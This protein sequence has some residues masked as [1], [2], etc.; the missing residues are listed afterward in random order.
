MLADQYHD[1][2]VVERTFELAWARSH[3]ELRHLHVPP[4]AAQLYQR[5]ASEVIFPTA[6]H[7]APAATIARNRLGQSGLWRHGVS[8]DDPIVL[9]RLSRPLHRSLLREVLLAHEFW[10][11]HG[12]KADLVV[13]NDNAAGYFDAMHEQLREVV[14]TTVRMPIDKS[15][16][17]HLLR[18]AHLQE[19]DDLLLNAAAAV[20]LEGDRGSLSQQFRNLSM[21]QRRGVRCRAKAARTHADFTTT[22]VATDADAG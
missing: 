21:P 9:V 14:Q 7:R 6:A 19:E 5:L 8:G 20:I 3:V 12:L 11:L 16:G 1:P 18:G 10:H 22:A 4:E 2:R 13:I 17:V 15:G